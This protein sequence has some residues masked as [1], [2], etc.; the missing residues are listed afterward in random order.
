[1][2]RSEMGAWVPTRVKQHEQWPDV[3]AR[4][5]RK[6][7]VEALLEARGVLLPEQVKE[8]YAHGV[9]AHRFG[10][11]QFRIDLGGIESCFLPHFEFVDRGFRNVVAAD[12]PG[13]L[14]VPL[15]GFL[16]G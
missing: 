16:F 15:V 3:M 10:P 7:L 8:E 11:A 2:L 4:G 12:E 13:L 1:M 14:C 6:E 5:D 9:H